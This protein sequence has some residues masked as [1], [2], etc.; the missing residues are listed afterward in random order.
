MMMSGDKEGNKE[1]GIFCHLLQ[2]ST[3]FCDRASFI[4]I[5]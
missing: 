3:D 1:K 4:Q 5:I 2:V